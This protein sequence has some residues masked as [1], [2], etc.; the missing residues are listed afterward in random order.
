MVLSRLPTRQGSPA[1]FPDKFDDG[2]YKPPAHQ[3]YPLAKYNW[4]PDDDVIEFYEGPHVYLVRGVPAMASMTQLAHARQE[5]FDAGA[6]IKGM[7]AGRSQPWPRLKYV[8]EARPLIVGKSDW[9]TKD[10]SILVVRDEKTVASFPTRSFSDDVEGEDLLRKVLQ[11]CG[12]LESKKRDLCG[13]NKVVGDAKTGSDG[14]SVWAYERAM[15]DSE[16]RSMWE[17]NGMEAR[18]R[19]TEAHYQL[20]LAVEGQPFRP[21]DVE[22]V[23]GFKFFGGVKD[24]WRGYRTEWEVSYQP[25]GLAGSIDL[26]IARGGESEEDGPLQLAIVDYKRSNK[27]ASSM[28]SPRRMSGAFS[29]LDDCDGASY[30]LQLSGYQ[31]MLEKM[32]FEVVD[33]LLVSVHP[34]GP[35]TVSVPY[36]KQEIEYLIDMEEKAMK[37]VEDTVDMCSE[38]SAPLDDAIR[39]E[40]RQGLVHRKIAKVREWT[41]LY[42]D[43]PTSERVRALRRKAKESVPCPT[44][45]T[46]WKRALK[47]HAS[48]PSP[49]LCVDH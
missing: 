43:V 5:E 45:G 22:V 32:G 15:A 34:D 7:K 40:E 35:Y 4:H 31:F 9:L 20:Q 13:D 46:T 37:A 17:A 19:G 10:H 24:E 23:E 48:S 25:A 21:T 12:L 3:T 30:A 14:D 39:V 11:T 42:E 33:R 36:L 18:N 6:V 49:V 27:L 28:T 44:F 41:I 8:R 29:H 26:L 2:S 47:D 1:P 16:I 38:T